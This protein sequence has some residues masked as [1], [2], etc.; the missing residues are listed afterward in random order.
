[1]L[2]KFYSI[3]WKNLFKSFIAF[4]VYAFAD[5]S[6]ALSIGLIATTNIEVIYFYLEKL[7]FKN[8]LDVIFIS[9]ILIFF[10][11]RYIF[12]IF[13]AKIGYKE[14]YI[15]YEDLGRK[16][17]LNIISKRETPQNYLR[18]GYMQKVLSKDIDFIIE[19]F[20]IP[21][22]RLFIEFIIFLTIYIFLARKIGLNLSI[23]VTVAS[24]ISFIYTIKRQSKANKKL[25]K[26]REISQTNK[27]KVIAM[28][29]KSLSDIYSYRPIEY[30]SNKF[31]KANNKTREN[32]EALINRI[33]IGRA[34]FETLFILFISLFIYLFVVS[35]KL[36]NLDY[37][38][39]II[40]VLALSTR[41]IPGIGRIIE[42]FQSIIYSWP[43]FKELFKESQIINKINLKENNIKIF[44]D[45]SLFLIK[46]DILRIE[47]KEIFKIKNFELN[48]GNWTTI[49]GESGAGKSTFL[50]FIYKFLGYERKR[51][52]QE[53]AYMPQSI[54][55]I[56]NNIYENIA[57]SEHYNK[58]EIDNLLKEFGL[59]NLIDRFD[60]SNNLEKN[61]IIDI[62]G[63]QLQRIII[64]RAI[65]HKRNILILDEFTSSLD[66]KNE[67]KVLDILK[68]KQLKNHLTIICSSH[69]KLTEKYSDN[70]YFIKDLNLNKLE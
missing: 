36:N 45:K 43:C 61:G 60:D 26:M 22:S 39:S 3:Y 19:G 10:I 42:S 18:P 12:L 28:I 40:I 48:I 21:V 55:M 14:I 66:I 70:I 53:I 24:L 4:T 46:N 29:E 56:S 9:V 47:N 20:I 63:G 41:L 65:Y 64:M 7:G 5:L 30:I 8:N 49:Y 50:S 25:G 69:K 54:S 59:S 51:L 37:K 33:I 58:Y 1:M 23:I 31:S 11:A 68:E 6:L 35:S 34:N 44:K 67:R 32:S 57:L 13:S 16:S 15:I 17:I 62:S 52:L 2:L 38:N 27:S